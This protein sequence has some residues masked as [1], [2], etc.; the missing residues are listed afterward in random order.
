[1]QLENRYG[2]V[3]KRFSAATC[4]KRFAILNKILLEKVVKLWKDGNVMLWTMKT[5]EERTEIQGLIYKSAVRIRILKE[6]E[7]LL[8]S[9]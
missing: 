6:A 1:M 3:R 8:E 5:S 2:F 4:R 9:R 7:E